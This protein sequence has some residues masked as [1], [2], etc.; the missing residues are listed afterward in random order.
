MCKVLLDWPSVRRDIVVDAIDGTESI[1]IS[2]I[3]IMAGRMDMV[4]MAVT[5][6][7]VMDA[8]GVIS[9]IRILVQNIIMDI[10]GIMGIMDTMGIMGT[11]VVISDHQP[12]DQDPGV[13]INVTYRHVTLDRWQDHGWVGALEKVIHLPHLVAAPE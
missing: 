13:T 11:R 6:I 12:L 3:A 7:I 4:D 9:R 2:L 10:M 1:C 8:I 5:V